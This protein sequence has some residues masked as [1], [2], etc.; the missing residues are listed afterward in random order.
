MTGHQAA[1]IGHAIAG[2]FADAIRHGERV[3]GRTMTRAE[4]L[5]AGE[6]VATKA[7]AYAEAVLRANGMTPTPELMDF[8]RS[9]ILGAVEDIPEM[10]S[11]DAVN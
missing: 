6:R 10:F 5:V 1:V 7:D 3:R 4:L 11:A 8:A 9:L 2:S